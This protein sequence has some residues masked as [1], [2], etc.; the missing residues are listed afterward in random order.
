MEDK[1]FV[2]YRSYF[3]KYLFK[4]ASEKLERAGIEFWATNTAPTQNFRVPQSA[5]T[6]IELHVAESDLEKV[7]ELLEKEEE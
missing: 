4:V 7:V 1:K 3:D 6:E 5:F 2:L